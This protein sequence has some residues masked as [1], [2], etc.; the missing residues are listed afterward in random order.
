MH[1][2]VGG[3]ALDV[4]PP[5][6]GITEAVAHG[7]LDPQGGELQAL[8]RAFLR[9][10]VDAQRSLDAEVIRPIDGSHGRIQVVLVAVFELAYAP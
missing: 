5:A 6:A 2:Y 7:V 10:D 1:S 3:G 4:R 9:R 8:E